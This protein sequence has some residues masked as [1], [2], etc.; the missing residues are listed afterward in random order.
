M[1]ALARVPLHGRQGFVTVNPKATEGARIGTNVWN[2]DGSLYVPATPVAAEAGG[3][4]VT[5]WSLVQD[6]PANVEGVAAMA[7]TGFV[8]KSG[9][10]FSASAIVNADLASAD[11]DGLAEGATNLYFTDARA[12][13][14]VGSSGGGSLNPATDLINPMMDFLGK[15]PTITSAEQGASYPWTAAAIA[16]SGGSIVAING[17]ATAPGV[18]QMNTG[19]LT[20]GIMAL[21]LGAAL[22]NITTGGGAIT[23]PFRFRVPVLSTGAQGFSVN[24]GLR[25]SWTGPATERLTVGYSD[26]LNSGK[27]VLQGTVG[28]ANTVANG[29]TTVA[30]NTW[31]SG[32][33][34]VNAA[35]TQA[36]L[37]INNGTTP[38]ATLSTGLPTGAMSLGIL[39]SKTLGTT[40]RAVDF[41][42]LDIQQTFT[43]AR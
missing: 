40:S 38:E 3:P 42:Y 7:G 35:G 6:I 12:I 4:A 32:R 36:D 21:E 30:A 1:T 16:A 15:P 28:G 22:S 20:N 25:N 11:T 31:V 14:A 43:T 2:A 24:I 9:S 18:W 23:I 27:V 17:G 5:L 26:T 34:V 33:I 10:S 37:Y 39:V 29:T 19:T 8:R 41:D 13:A